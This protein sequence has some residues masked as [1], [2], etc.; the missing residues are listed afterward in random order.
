[1]KPA[2]KPFP[3]VVQPPC[4]RCKQSVQFLLYSRSKKEISVCSTVPSTTA[5]RTGQNYGEETI[6]VEER[7]Q[8]DPEDERHGEEVPE[9]FSSSVRASTRPF[10]SICIT[11]IV[12]VLLL[13]AAGTFHWLQKPSVSTQ[14]S[15]DV[16]KSPETDALSQTKQSE[17]QGQQ[18]A[19]R[20]E[21]AE[22]LVTEKDVI[23]PGTVQL[24]A[25]NFRR[26]DKCL[27]VAL[28]LSGSTTYEVH[29]LRQPDRIYIDFYRVRF[30]PGWEQAPALPADLIRNVRSSFIKGRRARVVFDL[31]RPVDFL[32]VGPNVRHRITLCL[33]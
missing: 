10:V 29:R 12:L 6:V 32:V 23:H 2:L 30:A 18:N 28:Q 20:I 16:V 19:P 13:V 21:T 31:A 7:I 17:I 33:Y 9:L 27:L 22:P 11:S 14:H 25:V 1:V 4:K 26:D 24:L 8:K 5:C 15:H 3:T